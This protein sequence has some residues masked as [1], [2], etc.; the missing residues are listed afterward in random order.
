[1]QGFGA[2]FGCRI[3]GFWFRDLHFISASSDGPLL[4]RKALALRLIYCRGLK[5]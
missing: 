5:N 3:H 4:G 2:G 1:M